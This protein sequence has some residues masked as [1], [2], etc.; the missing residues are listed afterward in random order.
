[1]LLLPSV[2]GLKLTYWTSVELYSVE[3]LTAVININL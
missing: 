3:Y 1:M 2:A